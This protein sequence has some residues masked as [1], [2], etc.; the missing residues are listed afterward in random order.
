[1]G[2]IATI[3]LSKSCLAGSPASASGMAWKK[4]TRGFTIKLPR[5]KL[6]APPG[7]RWHGLK[8]SLCGIRHLTAGDSAA[9]PEG[10][11]DLSQ[12]SRQNPWQDLFS[13]AVNQPGGRRLEMRL[14][15]K[16]GRPF[17]LLPPDSRCAAAC[18]DL[19]PAQTSRAR[20]ALRLLRFLLRASLTAGTQTISLT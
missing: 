11:S 7:Q 16:A 20:I 14:L 2:A 9:N 12:P 3:R 10:V 5:A 1:M 15:K 17:F 13:G 8:R 4:P 18:L 19:Y 6:T